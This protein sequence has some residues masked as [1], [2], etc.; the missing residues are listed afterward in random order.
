MPYFGRQLSRDQIQEIVNYERELAAA[1]PPSPEIRND[2]ND[3]LRA[4]TP[5]AANRPSP[6][7]DQ[8]TGSDEDATGETGSSG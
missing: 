7:G 8:S 1:G 5:Q 3:T 4:P 2:V 6:T